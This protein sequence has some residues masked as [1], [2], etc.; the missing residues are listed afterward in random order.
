MLLDAGDGIFPRAAKAGAKSNVDA[1][2]VQVPA[3]GPFGSGHCVVIAGL[4]IV[5]HASGILPKSV[6]N[7]EP[8]AVPHSYT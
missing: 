2:V 6:I 8:K 4:T 5:F 7:S 3:P 1:W